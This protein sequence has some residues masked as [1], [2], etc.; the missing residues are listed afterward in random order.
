MYGGVVG[1]KLDGGLER[2]HRFGGFSGF[3]QTP[4]E[5]EMGFS[6]IRIELC[7]AR[8]MLDGLGQ[9]VSLTRQ[10]AQIILGGG[11]VRKDLQFLFEF[12]ASLLRAGGG[13]RPRQDQA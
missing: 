4:S 6:K 8:K 12:L 11:I 2:R 7:G 13:T 9:L 1:D 3:K 10:L 5:A